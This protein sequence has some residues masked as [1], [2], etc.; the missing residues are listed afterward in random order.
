MN[1]LFITVAALVTLFTA[2]VAQASDPVNADRNGFY[3]G[4]TIGSTLQTNSKIS[5]GLETGYQWTPYVRTELTYDYS[6]LTVG[7]SSNLVA[8]V[9]GQYRIPNSTVTPYVL[10]GTGFGF[11]NVGDQPNSTTGIYNAG[12]G[13]RIAVSRSVE[14]DARYRYVAPYSYADGRNAA[15]LLTVGANYRF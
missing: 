11:Y 5:T 13:V 15:N 8:N 3:L 2:N 12:A 4:G 6:W 10:V 14:L 1:K 9:V 7:N